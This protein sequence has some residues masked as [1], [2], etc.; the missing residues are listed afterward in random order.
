MKNRI[1]EK[2]AYPVPIYEVTAGYLQKE[3]TEK[4][5]I[6]LKAVVIEWILL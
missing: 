5:D 2:Y 4:K 6:G 1:W 3:E